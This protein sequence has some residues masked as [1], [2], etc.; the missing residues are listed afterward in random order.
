MQMGRTLYNMW[1]A[2]IKHTVVTTT[3]KRQ[4][5]LGLVADRR[6]AKKQPSSKLEVHFI[7][8]YQSKQ[9]LQQNAEINLF[10]PTKHS[11]KRKMVESAKNKPRV[12]QVPQI[13]L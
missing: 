8:V 5:M 9:S 11:N 2:H 7:Y 13:C 12:A 1:H 10:L 4:T 3:L 6:T